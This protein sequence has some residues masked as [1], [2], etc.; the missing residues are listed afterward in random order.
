MKPFGRHTVSKEIAC[1][2]TQLGPNPEIGNLVKRNT[3][4]GS[5]HPGTLRSDIGAKWADV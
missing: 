4:E 5:L 1:Y 2:D 3:E